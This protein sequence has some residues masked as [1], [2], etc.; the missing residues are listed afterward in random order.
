VGVSVDVNEGEGEGV[1]D[2]MGV[3][4]DRSGWMDEFR[5]LQFTVKNECRIINP[6][7]GFF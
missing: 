6:S 5:S 2:G 4:V 1:D 7:K 3:A